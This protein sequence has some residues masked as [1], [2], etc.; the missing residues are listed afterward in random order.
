[1]T[2]R[3]PPDRPVTQRRVIV[4]DETHVDRHFLR[5]AQCSVQVR[6]R[7]LRKQQLSERNAIGPYVFAQRIKAVH[8][9]LGRC[10]AE[11]LIIFD[12]AWSVEKNAGI[13]AAIT[14][15][16]KD[17]I[18]ICML[19]QGQTPLPIGDLPCRAT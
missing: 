7:A 1:M 9:D 18:E 4:H 13:E 19:C 17:D 2:Q 12:V 10:R 15:P 5:E 16:S 6:A 11:V 3:L 14:C 8:V